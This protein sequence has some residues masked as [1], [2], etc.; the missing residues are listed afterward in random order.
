MDLEN[1]P[2]SALRTEKSWAA[3]AAR[4]CCQWRD[5]DPSDWHVWEAAARAQ[6]LERRPDLRPLVLKVELSDA[7]FKAVC[8]LEA[9]EIA[10]AM[11]SVTGLS[12]YH[13]RSQ[14]WAAAWH[15][16]AAQEQLESVRLQAAHERN[17][18]QAALRAALQ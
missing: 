12:G 5:G 14:R 3:L 10:R 2:Q 6:L 7:A 15:G 4:N 9:L 8:H 11:G 18:L 13:P 17:V 16:S 1:W